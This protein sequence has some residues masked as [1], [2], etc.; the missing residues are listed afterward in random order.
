MIL[1]VDTGK[2]HK[3]SCTFIFLTQVTFGNSNK[4]FSFFTV[5]HTNTSIMSVHIYSYKKIQNS[6]SLRAESATVN[7]QK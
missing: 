3:Y 1:K 5:Q 7:W 4:T 6:P 2:K